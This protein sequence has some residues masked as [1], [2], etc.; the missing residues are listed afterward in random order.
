MWMKAGAFFALSLLGFALATNAS[1][2]G[3]GPSDRVDV[4]INDTLSLL[5]QG[6]ES[7]VLP[8]T[9]RAILVVGN[10]GAG[11][12]TVVQFVAGDPSNLVAEGSRGQY[13]ISDG[14]QRIGSSTLKSQTIFPELV[15]HNET[16]TAIYDC[17]GFSDTRDTAHDIAATYVTK[18]VASRLNELKF[19]F[20][21][22]Y[23]SVRRGVDRY[24]FVKLVWHATT[25]IRDLDK[26]NQSMGLVVS[27]VD[28]LMAKKP[29]GKVE[30]VPDEQILADVAAFMK[31]AKEYFKQ[32]LNEDDRLKYEGD[33]Y[34]KA[35]Q[36]VDILLTI[37]SN[38]TFKNLAIFRRPNKAGP[39]DS[40]PLLMK[41]RLDIK[42]VMLNETIYSPR[43]AGDLRYTVSEHSKLRIGDLMRALSEKCSS[44]MNAVLENV[45]QVHSV[46]AKS[47][48][49]ELEKT[50]SDPWFVPSLQIA[51]AFVNSNASVSTLYGKLSAVIHNGSDLHAASQYL[52]D[53]LRQGPLQAAKDFTPEMNETA[54]YLRYADFL[55]EMAS[56]DGTSVSFDLGNKLLDLVHNATQLNDQIKATI[57]RA[58]DG[59][60]SELQSSFNQL[61]SHVMEHYKRVKMDNL[62]RVSRKL[63][64]D[65]PALQ[66][67]HREASFLSRSTLDAPTIGSLIQDRLSSLGIDLPE[68]WLL[69]IQ[70]QSAKIPFLAKLRSGSSN[71]L[72]ESSFTNRT[73]QEI[74][75][76]VQQDELWYRFLIALIDRLSTY[77][78]QQN[79][80][81]YDLRF[82]SV[83]RGNFASLIARL[84]KNFPNPHDWE[85]VTLLPE[86]QE[87]IIDLGQVLD[88]TVTVSA[89]PLTQMDESG[90]FTI[91]GP[92]IFMN[93]VL[94]SS[95]HVAMPLSHKWV[96][97]H[98]LKSFY[99]DSDVNQF[100]QISSF[101]PYLT[102][103]G[104]PTMKLGGEPGS[105]PSPQK[106]EAYGREDDE[107][108]WEGK[109]PSG[110]PGISGQPG[111]SFYSLHLESTGDEGLKILVDGG[112]GGRGQ[113]GADGF[114]RSPT[115]VEKLIERGLS[116]AQPSINS[117]GECD[118]A[119]TLSRSCSQKRVDYFFGIYG[120]YKC[121]CTVS[122]RMP[123]GQD[124]GDGGRGGDGA[125]GGY[126][127]LI[128][129]SDNHVMRYGSQQYR[130]HP[131]SDLAS[132]FYYF[133]SFQ[134]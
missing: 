110:R 125:K 106:A 99:I 109:A 77:E 31:D 80:D 34:T 92:Y 57:R 2:P 118:I 88:A 68:Q 78:F 48:E 105:S 126:F 55:R 28:N 11:K 129:L 95:S 132:Q 85:E 65:L 44:K 73:T 35:I 130:S 38:D 72:L 43:N 124:G 3:N 58:R 47:L 53:A 15:V 9:G 86:T 19:L 13:L 20:V 84:I 119:T 128:R 60:K 66:T 98:A 70:T 103:I 116:N 120:A 32:R 75:M 90:R 42:R 41:N 107:R 33:F 51:K 4:E 134:K 30:L 27:K 25:F 49:I 5:R 6:E 1:Q 91:S 89:E 133:R 56:Q 7:V 10:S 74:A 64:Q 14:N 46:L 63:L 79:K 108:T 102:V 22:S 18:L 94:N 111:G 40:M 81:K 37:G 96:V 69:G 104:A 76:S 87:R 127:Q 17:P 52:Y 97:I 54:A 29:G 82:V 62:M 39:L 12:S 93:Q 71:E 67:L 50:A 59:V 23:Q 26:F 100:A 123:R 36:F 83:N 115:A 8:Q 117:K 61:Q 24:D 45:N 101:S 113:D 16:G 21:V 112:N 114:P 131:P 121:Y 122:M